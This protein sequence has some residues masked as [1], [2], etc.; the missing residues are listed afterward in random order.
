M[1]S[2]ADEIDSAIRLLAAGGLVAFPTE[3]VWGIAADARQRDA[4]ERLRRFKGRDPAQPISLLIAEPDEL[5]ALGCEVDARAR[6]LIAAFWPGPVTLVLPL[7]PTS[8]FAPLANTGGG[9]GIRCSPHPV[10]RGLALRAAVERA[11]AYLLTA[12]KSAPGLGH[13]SGPVN[14]GHTVRPTD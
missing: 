4:V 9:L 14:H 3:T 7:A 2:N 5:A 6:G 11:R 8:A 10:A 1:D 13:G 12:I